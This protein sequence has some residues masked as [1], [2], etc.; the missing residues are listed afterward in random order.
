MKKKKILITGINGQDG[1]YLANFL[2]NKKKNIKIYGLVRRT[3]NY[4]LNRLECFGIEKKIELIYSDI[5]EYDNI[6]KILNNIK[7]DVLFNLA[8]QSFVDYSFTNPKTTFQINTEAVF[9]ML[10]TIKQLK[11]DTKFYQASTSEMYGNSN[12]LRQNE[13]TP[14]SPVSPYGISKAQ[15]FEL[16][17]TYRN[18]FNIF[19]SNGILFNHE[20]PYRGSEFVTKKIISSLTKIKKGSREVLNLGNIDSARDWGYAGDYMFA[21]DKIMKNNKP[22]DFVVAT[23]KTISVRDFFLKSCNELKL[24]VVKDNKKGREV[25]INRDNNRLIMVVN[26]K[27]FRQNELNYLCGD[28]SKIKKQLGWKPKSDIND[29]IKIMVDFETSQKKQ[30]YNNINNF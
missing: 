6:N 4:K 14:F 28:Y 5:C 11:L 9:N 19:A 30:I 12:K 23:G 29:L 7:P 10:E 21:I 26:K 16:V 18:V 8:A 13:S 15:S 17:K 27:L 2:L 20:S 1:A 3:A 25:Y 22:D 24:N